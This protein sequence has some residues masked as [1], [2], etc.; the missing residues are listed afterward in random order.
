MKQTAVSPESFF[1]AAKQSEIN[2]ITELKSMLRWVTLI[3][4][5][6]HQLQRERGLSN[7]LLAGGGEKTRPQMMA[8]LAQTDHAREAMNEGLVGVYQ[9]AIECTM[10]A[11]LLNL[12]ASA[13]LALEGLPALRT[14]IEKS[15]MQPVDATACYSR[16]IEN[17]LLIVFEVADHATDPDVTQ[18]LST[19]F[20]LIQGKELVG[21]ERAWTVVG[22]ARGSFSSRLCERLERVKQQQVEIFSG[23]QQTASA[24]LNTALSQLESSDLIADFKQ[25]RTLRD[26]LQDGQQV[27]PELAD[28]WYEKAT[29][30]IDELHGLEIQATEQIL[31]LCDNRVDLAKRNR[32]AAQDQIAALTS[33]NP[34]RDEVIGRGLLNAANPS[35]PIQSLILE[36]RKQILDLTSDLQ[37]AKEALEARKLVERAKSILKDNMNLDEEAAYRTLQKSAMDQKLPIQQVALAIIEAYKRSTYR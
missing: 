10:S 25:L 34:N 7:R 23:F 26:R 15:R 27:N 31:T 12:I 28:T 13:L 11:K 37:R 19:L 4:E 35:H 36:Q 29:L 33:I 18:G 20:H 22:F 2:T 1:L 17:L 5:F 30:Y 21:Q 9:T 8:Q 6:I 3:C 24:E 16:L 14:D 32:S